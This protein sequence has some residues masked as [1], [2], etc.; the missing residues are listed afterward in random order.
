MLY[1]ITETPVSLKPSSCPY[2]KIKQVRDCALAQ[3]PAAQQ[4]V[5]RQ[6]NPFT[7]PEQDACGQITY[8]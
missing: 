2:K 5:S 6:L 3:E 8:W 1:F 4:L 7:S